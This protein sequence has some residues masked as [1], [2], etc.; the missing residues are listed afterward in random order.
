MR[1]IVG[2]AYLVLKG[3]NIYVKEI[4]TF[5]STVMDKTY[6]VKTTANCKTR[7]VVY[8]IKCMKS[9]NALHICL[10][11]HRSDIPYH[12]AVAVHVGVADVETAAPKFVHAKKIIH[13]VYV[14]FC[15]KTRQS[16]K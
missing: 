10:N 8:V 16:A 9:G 13:T 7:V 15:G 2:V 12:R 1:A 6:K 11:G 3:V 5:S 14:T 4:L